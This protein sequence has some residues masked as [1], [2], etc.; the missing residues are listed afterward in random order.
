MRGRDH[1]KHKDR[2]VVLVLIMVAAMRASASANAS[3]QTAKLPPRQQ[4]PPFPQV[5][6]TGSKTSLFRYHP[7]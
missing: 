3:P 4:P 2:L 5:L 6:L 7:D 1:D